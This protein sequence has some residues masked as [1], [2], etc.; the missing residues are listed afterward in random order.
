MHGHGNARVLF[1]ALPVI[2][3]SA[4]DRWQRA[5]RSDFAAS[6]ILDQLLFRVLIFLAARARC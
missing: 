6:A 1:I 4:D 5:G 3:H 2:E